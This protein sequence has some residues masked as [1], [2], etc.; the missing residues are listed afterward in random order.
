MSDMERTPNG[1]GSENGGGDTGDRAAHAHDAMGAP[2]RGGQE[3]VLG[4]PDAADERVMGGP[5]SEPDEEL[6]GPD[7][8]GDGTQILGADRPEAPPDVFGN[9]R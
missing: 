5:N 7:D 2:D 6:L 3:S 1:P 4:S 8:V 9:E